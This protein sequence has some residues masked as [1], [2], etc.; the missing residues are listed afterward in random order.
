MHAQRAP[1]PRIDK[2]IRTIARIRMHPAEHVA[3]LVGANGNQAEIKGAAVGADLREGGAH[4]EVG[5]GGAIVVRVGG[6]VRDGAVAGVA[7]GEG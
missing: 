3:R 5:E 6:E 1:T 2:D 7:W 4:G